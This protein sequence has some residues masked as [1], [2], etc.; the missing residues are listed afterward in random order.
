MAGEGPESAVTAADQ[1]AADP[2]NGTSDA[3]NA[4]AA[5][6]VDATAAGASGEKEEDPERKKKREEKVGGKRAKDFGTR[7][8]TAVFMIFPSLDELCSAW[9]MQKEWCPA[10]NH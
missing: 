7:N 5:K 8:T 4:D 10:L 1:P 9:Y 3:A 6:A 2:A